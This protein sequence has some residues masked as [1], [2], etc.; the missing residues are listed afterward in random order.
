MDAPE[1]ICCG[2]PLAVQQSGGSLLQ[3][4]G[5]DGVI[6]QACIKTRRNCG[7]SDVTLHIFC[8]FALFAYAKLGFLPHRGLTCII[9]HAATT[10]EDADSL[11]MLASHLP[12]GAHKV[13]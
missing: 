9:I 6:L 13:A 10:R 1:Q 11:H 8:Y 3:A 5:R 7:R 4:E 12:G 2:N